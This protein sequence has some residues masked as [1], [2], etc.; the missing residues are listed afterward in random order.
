MGWHYAPAES[1]NWWKRGRNQIRS[2]WNGIT[3]RL[4]V[5]IGRTQVSIEFAAHGL[6][7]RTNWGFKL[8]ETRSVSNSQHMEKHYTLPENSNWLKRGQYHIR[9]TWNAITHF[10]GIQIGWKEVGNEFIAHGMILRTSWDFKFVETKSGSNLQHME[11]HYTLP[12][13]SNWSKQGQYEFAAHEWHYAPTESSNSSKRGQY[14]IRSTWNG[15]THILRVQFGRNKV[16]IKFAAHGMGLRTG[17]E[18]NLVKTRSVSN[19]QPMEWDY[20]PAESSIWSKRGQYRICS[21]WNG[22]THWLRVQFGR[23]EVSIEFAAHGIALR[24]SSEFNL[25]KTRSVSNSQH[26]EW[27]YALADSPNWSKPDQ[28]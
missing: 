24:T 13:H 23:N 9:S 18:F 14:W 15:I 1:S 25:V 10:L 7:L 6:A 21:T 8:V 26:M 5:Q 11:W 20:A 2:T 4:R 28:Y 27:H 17:W 3:H 16:S 12:E 22:T 19:S